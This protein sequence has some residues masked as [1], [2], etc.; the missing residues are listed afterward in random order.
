MTEKRMLLSNV[1]I[2]LGCCILASV[3]IW[4]QYSLLQVT[5]IE[6]NQDVNKAIKELRHI[7]KKLNDVKDVLSEQ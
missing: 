2:I 3:Y 6:V 1:I 7:H 4:I 5:L